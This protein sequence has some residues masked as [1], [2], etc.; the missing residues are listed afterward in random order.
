MAL[1]KH[2]RLIVDARYMVYEEKQCE[3]NTKEEESRL[4]HRL[5]QGQI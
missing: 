1:F 4:S 3:N 5:H 2:S